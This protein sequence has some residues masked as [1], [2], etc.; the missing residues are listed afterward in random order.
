LNESTRYVKGR[1][2]KL[3]GSLVFPIYQTSAY[4]MPLGEKYRYSREFNP[5]VEAL[6]D[7]IAELEDAESGASF[8]SGMGAI[9]TSLLANL[10][11]GSRLLVQRDM[12]ART[13]KFA[14]EFLSSWKVS[15][16]PVDPGTDN[17]VSEIEKGAD[18]AVFESVTNPILRV[19]D[20]RRISKAAGASG[21]RIF[22][23]STLVTPVNQK[24][25]S[26][27][28]NLVIHSASKFIA[29][30]NDAI[31]GLVAGSRKEVQRI[32]DLRRTLGPSM[33]PN[34]AFLVMRGIR[35]L[36]VRMDV[37]NKSAL[38]IAEVLSENHLVDDVIYPG[39]ESH[40]DHSIAKEM[41]AGFGGVISF[42]VRNGRGN[43]AKFMDR[44]RL[45]VPANTLGGS[46]TTISN[47]F[48]MS[49]RGLSE[50]E[51]N[52][53]GITPDLFR[54]SVGLEDPA[55]IVEDIDTAIKSIQH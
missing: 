21:C 52:R 27:G 26:L 2:E 31:A 9:T 22:A 13:Y 10:K 7:K 47:P 32:D 23:D 6:S 19:N 8:S 15:V 40:P 35:T 53:I 4:Q 16:S 44:L 51:K 48:T 14:T 30:H 1:I 11:P 37:I 25:L 33:D 38:R 50:E 42:R 17:M 28:A 43:E 34:T 46:E 5:T 41:L 45:C 3:N 36:K 39:L 20:I 24:P 18:I 29:G 54:L 49:H 12:F 55:D